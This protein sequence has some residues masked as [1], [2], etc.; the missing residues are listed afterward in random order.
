LVSLKGSRHW[1]AKITEQDAL[2]IRRLRKK[3]WTWGELRDEYGISQSGLRKIVSGENWAH[4]TEKSGKTAVTAGVAATGSQQK[5]CE[6]SGRLLLP[7]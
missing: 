5:R 3:G 4:V 7:A 6:K 1:K 2:E